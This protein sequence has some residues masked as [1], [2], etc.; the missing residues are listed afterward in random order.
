MHTLSTAEIEK[1]I[2]KYKLRF[3]PV[4]D[5]EIEWRYQPPPFVLAFVQFIEKFQSIPPQLEF[6][7]YYFDINRRVLREDAAQWRDKSLRDEKHRAL[8]AR[9]LRAYPSFVRDA[10]LYA[11]LR[12]SGVT[13]S[14]DATQDV[15]SGVDLI[16][17]NA[18]KQIQIHVLLDSPRAKLGRAK[19]DSRHAFT[20]EHFDL[21]LRKEE[22]KCVGEFW[23]PT[24]GHVSQIQRALDPS[25]S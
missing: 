16:A 15:E 10:Y 22:C 7:D 2:S 17:S 13:V 24:L 21:V 4:H 12:E 19:K 1:Q 20:G 23:L 3:S 11:L 18:R 6:Q 25:S 5:D 8:K 14:Y 9:L